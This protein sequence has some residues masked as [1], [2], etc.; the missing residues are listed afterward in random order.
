MVALG[1]LSHPRL[2]D[3]AAKVGLGP[4]V[5]DDVCAVAARM[6][7]LLARQLTGVVVVNE[8]RLLQLR[9]QVA[10]RPQRSHRQCRLPLAGGHDVRT[11]RLLDEPRRRRQHRLRRVQR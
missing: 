2:L 8:P 7:F 9:R 11:A 6:Q 4:V 3:I 5:V 1:Y 10:R